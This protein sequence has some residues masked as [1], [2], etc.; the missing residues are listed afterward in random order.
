MEFLGDV[1][2]R[3]LGQLPDVS[4]PG[5]SIVMAFSAAGLTAGVK[6]Q[7]NSLRSENF[8]TT[9]GRN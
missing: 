2:Q 6:L 3:A 1:V 9:R 4:S 8:L 7:N 5:P